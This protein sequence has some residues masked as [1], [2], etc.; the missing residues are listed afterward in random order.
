MYIKCVRLAVLHRVTHYKS[1]CDSNCY[2]SSVLA[3]IVLLLATQIQR[4]RSCAPQH[5]LSP[6]FRFAVRPSGSFAS[7]SSGVACQ[8]PDS[9]S[10]SQQ[11]GCNP[12]HACARNPPPFLLLQSPTTYGDAAH[13]IG[14]A[15]DARARGAV[16][17]VLAAGYA[18]GYTGYSRSQQQREH[19]AARDRVQHHLAQGGR[20]VPDA[21]QAQPDRPERGR[22]RVRLASSVAM[23]YQGVR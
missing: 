21:H 4:A 1:F 8:Q 7:D 12:P 18:T 20:A 14:R 17:T 6:H 15:P 9:S 23:G 10:S 19:V 3:L 22:E 11:Q 2:F 16:V 13:R 5:F